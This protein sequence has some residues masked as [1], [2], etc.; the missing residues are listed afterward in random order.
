MH[1]E[2]NYPHRKE[3]SDLDLGLADGTDDATYLSLLDLHFKRIVD[4]EQPD[5]ILYQSG[6]DVLATD[7]LGR[8]S[9]T[10]AGVQAR[11]RLVLSTARSLGI[12]IMCCMGGG[13]SKRIKDIVEGHAQVFRLAQ[14]LFF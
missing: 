9:L 5:F 7:Q 4:L 11:D 12:P 14:D 13:Y 10:L 6:V 2:K 3:K 8:L 1:G